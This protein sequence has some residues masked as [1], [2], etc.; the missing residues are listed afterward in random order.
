[1]RKIDKTK[2]LSGQYKD[3]VDKLDR[4]NVEH[5]H[6]SRT[7]YYDVVMNLLYCQK[8]VCAYTEMFLCNPALFS[9]NKWKNGKYQ[10]KSPECFGELD[11]FD[12]GLKKEKYWEWK[13]LFVIASRINK[14]KGAQEVDDVLKPD[15]SHYDPMELLE[16]NDRFH[17]FI[18]HTGI[19]DEARR[20]NIQRMIEVLQ[21][22][23]DLVSRERR[24]FLKEAFKFRQMG[25]PFEIDRFFTAYQM[26][27]E[28]GKEGQ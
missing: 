18:P 2:I 15:S 14:R 11:H 5:P 6:D 22:N 19:K 20:K 3:W 4:D 28:T 27:A 13:N 16:Y 25:Q 17:I 8:G 23:Y 26:A 7:Y 24:R 1:M 12:P 9:E 10:L 21:L